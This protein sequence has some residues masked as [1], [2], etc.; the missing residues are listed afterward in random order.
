MA[1]VFNSRE[2]FEDWCDEH[3][4][5]VDDRDLC[6]PNP[7]CGCNDCEILRMPHSPQGGVYRKDGAE[8][9][10]PSWFGSQSGKARCRHC[11]AV[12]QIRLEMEADDDA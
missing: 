10:G 12:F 7:R 6:C 11:G 2:E 1:R 8:R 3:S 9:R 4:T 5:E